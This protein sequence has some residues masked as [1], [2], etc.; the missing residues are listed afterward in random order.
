[1]PLVSSD[2]DR[3]EFWMLYSVPAPQ[4]PLRTFWKKK[5]ALNTHFSST[6]L[7]E[8]E[9]AGQTVYVPQDTDEDNWPQEHQCQG[10]DAQTH[11]LTQTYVLWN[12]FYQ[13]ETKCQ[14]WSYVWFVCKFCINIIKY[15]TELE[16]IHDCFCCN[17]SNSLTTFKFKPKSKH[18]CRK[19][20]L[21]LIKLFSDG[22]RFLQ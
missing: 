11:T 10:W 13:H 9:E 4:I 20:C 21:L 3:T 6:D 12:L 17:I 16:R 22:L 15:I 18:L 1:M 7:C 14:L 2:Y 8:E 19:W 5:H